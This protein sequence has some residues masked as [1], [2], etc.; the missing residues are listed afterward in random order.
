MKNLSLLLILAVLLACDRENEPPTCVLISPIDQSYYY[1]GDPLLVW[2]E[3]SDPD[4]NLT[5]VRVFFNGTED[6]VI[7]AFPYFTILNT[8]GLETVDHDIRVVAT[9]E[10]GLQDSDEA[11]ITLREPVVG[12]T[13]IDGNTYRITEIGGR[14]WMAENLRVTRYADGTAIE[15]VD[16]DWDWFQLERDD[17]A[18][19]WYNDD[20]AN[21]EPFG[22]LYTWAAA[23]NGAD[24]LDSDTMTIQ[25]VCPDGWHMPTD[26]EWKEMEIHLGMSAAVADE[27]EKW[28]GEDVGGKLKQSGNYYWSYPNQGAT[29]ATG[30][31]GLPGR[32]RY[33]DGRFDTQDVAA[34]WTATEHDSLYSLYRG[35]ASLSDMV[36]RDY[37]D[38]T[39]GFSVRCVK[40]R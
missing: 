19:C 34:F 27:L 5:G 36:Y 30:F 14:T 21:A 29:D 15:N 9:D 13:D 40:D 20:T 17:R 39:S 38:K 12:L 16:Y 28:R 11:G 18:Y 3:V 37:F 31:S 33:Y 7:H 24:T 6:T 2:A 10:E 25:G 26:A 8:E 22:A 23:M 4:A 1:A 32:A 35:L